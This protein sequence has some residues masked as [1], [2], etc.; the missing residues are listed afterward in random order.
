[1]KLNYTLSKDHIKKYKQNGYIICKDLFDK[2]TIQKILKSIYQIEK[3][4]DAKGKWMKY[5]DFSL[6]NKKKRILTRI[7][8]FY[9]YNTELKKILSNKSLKTQLKKIIGQEVVL[10]KDKINFKNPGAQGFKPHQDAT[11]WR[12]MYGIKSFIS[13]AIAIDKSTVENGCLEFSKFNQRKL[14]SKPWKEIEKKKEKK[15]LW[16]TV[17]MNPGDTAI[18]HDYCPHRS[19]NNLSNKKRRMLF[20]TFNPKKYGNFRKKHFND[21]RENFPPNVERQ[22]G[23]KYV[24]HV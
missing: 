18:F 11:I 3:Y 4:K 24:Y 13:V 2:R 16:E 22:T 6:T 20:L 23:K 19:S 9:D 15:M 12:D 5:Y 17:E 21:K 1:M 14:L 7:E 8:N 10:F